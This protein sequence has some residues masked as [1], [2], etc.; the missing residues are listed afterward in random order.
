MN[1]RTCFISRLV[2]AYCILVSVLMAFQKA[3]YVRI[4]GAML[5]DPALLVLAGVLAVAAGLAIVIAHNVWSGGLR[6]RVVTLVGWV[7]LLKGITLLL[8]TPDGRTLLDSGA[9]GY[10]RYFHVYMGGTFL[11]G[12]YL[13]S[14]ALR[15]D[16]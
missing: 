2:G 14:A 15:K 4:I 9:I 6:P 3:A 7:V 1:G 8:F 5:E 12:V 11:L 16:G 13:A 10:E